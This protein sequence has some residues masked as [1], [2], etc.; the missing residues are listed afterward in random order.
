VLLTEVAQLFLG[1]LLVEPNEIRQTANR[2]IV[3][4][5]QVGVEVVLELVPE[6]FPLSRLFLQRLSRG[7]SADRCSAS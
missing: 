2:L 5:G 3:A 6:D 4:L 1:V 7:M